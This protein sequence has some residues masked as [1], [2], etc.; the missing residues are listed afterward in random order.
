ML[1]TMLCGMN[2]DIKVQSF[3][4]VITNS[5]S[6]VFCTIE[7]ERI[8]EICDILQPLFEDALYDIDPT[9][10]YNK[11]EQVISVWLP[12]DFDRVANFYKAG[13]EAILNCS[14]GNKNYN[15]SYV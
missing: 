1:G 12:L 5:S 14:V 15:I 7:S 13:L 2:L 8:Q 9:L 3:G 10:E 4:D 11:E 6:E